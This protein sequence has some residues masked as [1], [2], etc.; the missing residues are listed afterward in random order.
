MVELDVCKHFIPLIAKYIL[1]PYAHPASHR[2]TPPLHQQVSQAQE[3]DVEVELDGKF[4]Y[5]YSRIDP[6]QCRLTCWAE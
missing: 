5:P 6:D 3:D 1:T 2:H 4:S